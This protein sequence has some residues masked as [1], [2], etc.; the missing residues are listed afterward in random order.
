[1]VKKCFTILGS[2]VLTAIFLY[3][4][5][6]GEPMRAFNASE[7]TQPP[8]P[9]NASNPLGVLNWTAGLCIIGGVIAGMMSGWKIGVRAIFSGVGLIIVSYVVTVLAGWMVIPI[10]AIFT[11]VSAVWGYQIIIKAWKY[12]KR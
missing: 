6:F 7:W 11:V 5:S 9:D 4:C 3:G 10:L 12:K 2:L 8:L 1:V